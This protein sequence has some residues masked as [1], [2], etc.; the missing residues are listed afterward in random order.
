MRLPPEHGAGEAASGE[1]GPDEVRLSEMRFG[2]DTLVLRGFVYLRLERFD[3]AIADYNSALEINSTMA[4]SLYGR[5]LARLKKG[6]A[7]G[8]DA[9]IAAAKAIQP[10]I[11]EAFNTH[12]GVT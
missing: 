12:Y 1:T 10:D 9:D 5:G 3:N 8:G 4:I 6:D 2:A 11:V 7:T